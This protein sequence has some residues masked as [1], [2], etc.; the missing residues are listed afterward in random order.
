M[1]LALVGE[2]Q[3]DLGGRVRSWMVR[4]VGELVDSCR[5][6]RYTRRRDSPQGCIRHNAAAFAHR[7]VLS[8]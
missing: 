3:I 8:I 5:G 7:A 2:N 4:K 1:F 6:A